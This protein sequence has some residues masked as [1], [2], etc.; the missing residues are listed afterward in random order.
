MEETIDDDTTFLQLPNEI[1]IEADIKLELLS[2]PHKEPL[3]DTV[4]RNKDF[5]RDSCGWIEGFDSIDGSE[6]FISYFEDR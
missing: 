6:M 3:Y 5:L 2:Q 4:C 1:Q